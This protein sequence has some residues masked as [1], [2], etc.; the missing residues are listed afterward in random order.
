MEV[1]LNAPFKHENEAMK[2]ALHSC[3]ND[4][5]E[6]LGFSV[7]DLKNDVN[8]RRSFLSSHPSPF[9]QGPFLRPLGQN[10]FGYSFADFTS[11]THDE[12]VK[13]S[14]WSSEESSAKKFEP[15]YLKDDNLFESENAHAGPCS[16]LCGKIIYSCSI[17]NCQ[18]C[19]P[20]LLCQSSE[21]CTRSCLKH[22]CEA[23]D[24]QCKEHY[25][26][27]VRCF[28]KTEDLFTIV[29]AH[30][31]VDEAKDSYVF[32]KKF[33][34]AKFAKLPISCKKCTTD[35]RNHEVY[36]KVFHVRCKFCRFQMRAI[37]ESTSEYDLKKRKRSLLS[38]EEETCSFCF[39]VF[40]KKANRIYHERTVHSLKQ[41][42]CEICGRSL[43][44]QRSLAQHKEIYHSEKN[45]TFGCDECGKVLSTKS[46]L[47][48]HKKTVHTKSSNICQ[49]CG[50]K[51][52]RKNHLDR[53]MQEVHNIVTN[54]NLDFA[55]R[56]FKKTR[57]FKC[58]LCGT[59]FTRN[60]TLKRHRITLH[61]GNDATAKCKNCGKEFGRLDNL[62]RHE[63]TCESNN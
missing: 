27:M 17:G 14:F 49:I 28:N 29:T 3:F 16:T 19:C 23:C 62:R 30:G 18:V 9:L 8:R 53:H 6:S 24:S 15:K 5:L 61:E 31:V 22:P 32:Q 54:I 48:R 20:C 39:K 55:S 1:Q 36:H 47:E 13:C 57:K 42:K 21:Y 11:Y 25:I 4:S 44:S 46:I 41:I 35:L 34:F 45:E 33:F 43:N 51:I 56:D 52:S 12:S 38:D 58:E 2:S 50:L 40:N 59:A 63:T 26:N 37:E 10:I 7:D 60:E